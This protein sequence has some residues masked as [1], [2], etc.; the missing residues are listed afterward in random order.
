MTRNS[1][2]DMEKAAGK[3]RNISATLAALAVLIFSFSTGHAATPSVGQAGSAGTDAATAAQV[4][5]ALNADPTYF[6][7]HVDVQ[8]QHGVVTLTGY[9]WST[10]AIYRAEKIAASVPGVTR[11]V[12]QMELERSGLAPHA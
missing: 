8:I 6:F 2:H 3:V 5:D 4:Y 1:I 12:D 10:P 7:R 9:V 11:V